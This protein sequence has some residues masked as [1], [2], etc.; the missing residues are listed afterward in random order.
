[1]HKASWKY[2]IIA[3]LIFILVMLLVCSSAF[4]TSYYIDSVDGNDG[5][6][7][8]SPGVG[9]AWKTINKF[10][11]YA[12]L[13]NNDIGY[14]V[15]ASH[16]EPSMLLPNQG[17]NVT[18]ES[19]SAGHVAV[20]FASS[21]NFGIDTLSNPGSSTLTFRR[22]D[23]TDPTNITAYLVW[24]EAA[25]S[26]VFDNCVLGG[27]TWNRGFMR[28]DDATTANNM[29]LINGTIARFDQADRVTVSLKYGATGTNVPFGTFLIDHSTFKPGPNGAFTTSSNAGGGHI[30]IT[31]STIDMSL[32]SNG[33]FHSNTSGSWIDSAI[34][35][36]NTIIGGPSAG[37]GFSYGVDYVDI[38]N[39][40]MTQTS[41]GS[42]SDCFY[43]GVGGEPSYLPSVRFVKIFNNY[44]SFNGNGRSHGI[45]VGRGVVG[46]EVAYNVTRHGDDSFVIKANGINFHH[47][48]GYD[49]NY[50]GLYF[51]EG[52][53]NIIHH[54]TFTTTRYCFAGDNSDAANSENTNTTA[55]FLPVYL[56]PE[57]TFTAIGEGGTLTFNKPTPFPD[58]TPRMVIHNDSGG[59]LN[60]Y[61]GVTTFT[62][63]GLFRGKPVTEAITF[64]STA[65]NK[66]VTNGSYRYKSSTQVYDVLTSVTV[67]NIGDGGL[68]VSMAPAGNTPT[69]NTIT[70]NICYQTGNYAMFADGLT[71]NPAGF[72]TWFI[73]RNIYRKG[74]GNFLATS[75]GPTTF[76]T[77]AA[78]QAG[79]GWATFAAGLPAAYNDQNSVDADP[80]F[81]DLANGDLRI[82][83]N[84]PAKGTKNSSTPNL[85]VWND[86]G[87]W[88]LPSAA[89]HWFG[90]WSN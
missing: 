76:A 60:L 45:T 70:D 32:V 55:P 46:G 48:V 4:A 11:R 67:T 14:I 59:T 58:F 3:R 50:A 34:I 8:T 66:A 18:L 77:L 16:S 53:N 43:A 5:N 42:V 85:N 62:L 72:N 24:L 79:T 52:K 64:T 30:V 31:N 75:A 21:D 13:A 27:A 84:S 9:N 40:T 57:A 2:G 82:R 73:D 25:D 41:N 17:K 20:S 39:N 36:N 35:Q 12:S 74:T 69:F 80:G 33:G 23:F 83:S 51:R 38:S 78:A 71:G 19:Y 44:C 26:I 22:V 86:K 15:Q 68:K 56:A 1:M 81:I 7:G 6:A 10:L 87:A 28:Q 37:I 61:Q 63:V 88:Q 65:G 89:K 29:S 54:N 47:N 90:D 49:S